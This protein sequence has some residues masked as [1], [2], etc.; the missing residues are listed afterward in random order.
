MKNETRT[1]N[2]LVTDFRQR[3]A[4]RRGSSIL[5]TSDP[6]PGSTLKIEK[7]VVTVKLMSGTRSVADLEGP[8]K[9]F[10]PS[11]IYIPEFKQSSKP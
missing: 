4:A 2:R 5:A 8:T 7:G 10:G 9:A 11:K 6:A 3:G 1:E